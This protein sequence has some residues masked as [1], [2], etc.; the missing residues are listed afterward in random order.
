MIRRT[1][2]LRDDGFPNL[3]RIGDQQWR[4]RAACGG[5]E[6][7]DAIF[8]APDPEDDDGSWTPDAALAYCNICPVWAECLDDA[9]LSNDSG[10]RGR[11]TEADRNTIERFQKRTKKYLEF[12]LREAVKR[13]SV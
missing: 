3:T 1:L 4:N 9:L 7:G 2:S 12:D 8:F 13:N 11:T 10:V 6:N 5:V